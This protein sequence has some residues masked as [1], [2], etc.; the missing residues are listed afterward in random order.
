MLTHDRL[1]H[2]VATVDALEARTPEPYRLT[3][4]DNASCPEVR[5][6]LAEN[7]R[8]F[9][10][11][12]L[13]PTNEHV[14][15][16]THGIAAT[17]S[18]PFVVT[19]PDV[20]VP[21]LEPSWL[22]RMLDLVDRHP[23]FGLIGVGLD[24]S[25]RPSVLG[26]HR[27]DPEQVVGDELVEA[28]TGT[29]FQFIRRDALLTG[30]RSDGRA[31]TAVRRA[32]YRVGWAANVRGLHLGWDDFRLY[33]GH[34]LGKPLAYGIY[35]EIDLVRRP[36]TLEEVALAAPVLAETRRAEV[37]DAAVLE[38]AWGGPALAASAPDVLAL[39]DPELD[40]IPVDDA[41]A[42]AVVL[43]DPPKARVDALVREGCRVATTLV[44]A[45][46]PL[47]TF[48]ARSAAEVAPPGW[49]GREA[50]AV[51]DVPLGI[52]RA[53][54][55]D[56]MLA[57]QVA[58][59]TADHRERWLEL[60]GAARFGAGELRLWIWEREHPLPTPDRVV[61]DEATLQPWQAGTME[62]PPARRLGPIKRFWRRADLRERAAVWLGRAR[63]RRWPPS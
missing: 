48:D 14:P 13:R 57:G 63:R 15:A 26:P 2:L 44:V 55:A 60:F 1:E 16:F 18:D 11:L 22:A 34:L 32:G 20:V 37:P 58:G 24:D 28:G 54:D 35:R 3:I 50:P 17:V 9:H 56:A 52:A 7:R 59:S 46:A 8:R 23:D 21:E 19:D 25:N 53:A 33:P 40:A 41:A 47:D 30:Y 42:G 4:V 12:I 43:E 45:L 5:N 31:C 6:W 61:C 38:L 10:Q 49:R 36:P 39:A 29:V 62:A 51:G 27:I